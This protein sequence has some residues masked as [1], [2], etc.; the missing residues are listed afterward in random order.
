[1]DLQCLG[2]LFMF[3]VPFRLIQLLF[4]EKR[5]HGMQKAFSVG[6][7]PIL[8]LNLALISF[9]LETVYCLFCIHPKK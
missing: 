2:I 6:P 5:L 4:Y 9:H 8:S 3:S 7:N 1:M